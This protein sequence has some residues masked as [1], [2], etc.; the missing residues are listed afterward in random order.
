V[1]GAANEAKFGEEPLEKHV[2]KKRTK[3]RT[4]DFHTQVERFFGKSRIKILVRIE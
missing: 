4:N 1:I 2:P 3:K